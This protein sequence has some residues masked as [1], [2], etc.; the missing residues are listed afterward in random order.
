MSTIDHTK[1]AIEN[2]LKLV[3]NELVKTNPEATQ[4]TEQQVVFTTPVTIQEQPYNTE[5]RIN[6][7]EAEDKISRPIILEYSRLDIAPMSNTRS[8][9]TL[10]LPNRGEEYTEEEIITQAI[11]RLQ[12]V[13]DQVNVVVSENKDDV[14][15]SATEN[16]LLYI[17]TVTIPVE[18]AESE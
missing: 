13:R 15:I 16:S 17:G 18:L 10:T 8:F 7:S 6:P 14:T 9:T 4:I 2:I 11:S 5:L 3:H 12:V 1:S